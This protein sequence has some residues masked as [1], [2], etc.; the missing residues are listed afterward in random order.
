ELPT[1]LTQ[2]TGAKGATVDLRVES[3]DDEARLR[4][5][6]LLTQALSPADRARV[7]AL[8]RDFDQLDTMLDAAVTAAE[9]RL[10]KVVEAAPDGVEFTREAEKRQLELENAAAQGQRGRPRTKPRTS[11]LAYL[12]LM[13]S[14]ARG[15]LEAL[16]AEA[17]AELQSGY[18]PA[19][20]VARQMVS[21]IHP[22]WDALLDDERQGAQVLRAFAQLT[23]EQLEQVLHSTHLRI[24]DSTV[25]K[26]VMR[27]ATEVAHAIRRF[28][29]ELTR[30]AA[31]DTADHVS[32]RQTP[33]TIEVGEI[34]EA[35][36][37]VVNA[38]A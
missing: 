20:S 12:P 22:Q 9:E 35:A 36:R 30:H 14:E 32:D 15:F 33:H 18:R 27:G 5:E 19:K 17:R 6:R 1:R 2:R 3:I 21:A 7:E 37:G 13:V 29:G 31:P 8:I 25:A 16:R 28:E 4:A 38:W 26:Q 23:D 10:R 34:P 24:Q 11:P